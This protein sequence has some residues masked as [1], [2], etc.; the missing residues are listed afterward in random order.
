M[1]DTWQLQ[2]AK[3]QFGEL[4]EQAMTRGPQRVTR[5]G[6]PAVVVMSAD[7]YDRLTSPPLSLKVLLRQA[8]LDDVDLER[9]RDTG[10]EIDV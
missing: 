6:H 9:D 5:G 3:N 4:V 2:D 7:D 10:R 1:T 8:Q